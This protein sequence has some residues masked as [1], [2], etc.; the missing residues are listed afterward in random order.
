MAY[1]I[2]IDQGTTSTRAILFDHAGDVAG[3]GQVELTQHFPQPGWVEHDP[4][5]IWQS[6]RECVGLALAHANATAE[7][8]AAI[9]ITNQRE[10]AVVW[11]R[12]TGKPLHRAIVWQDARTQPFIDR[13]TAQH[14]ADAFAT[15]TGL[16]LA[17]Y[18][19]ASKY[20]WLLDHTGS[21]ERAERGEVLLGTI[22]SWL[23]WNL[24]G[25]AHG[26][27][28]ATDVTNASR[29]LLMDL[30]ERQWSPRMLAE[31]AIPAAAL[32]RI[33]TSTAAYGTAAAPSLLR[34]V[35]ITG[36]LGDQQAATFGQA[37]FAAGESKSTYGTG[38]FVLVNT[39]AEIVRSAHGLISTI[40]Y[41]LDTGEIAY[42]LE[43]S[44]AVTGAAVQWLRDS[45]GLITTASQV[46]SLAES[47]PDSGGVVFVPA[48]SGL[49]A[50]HWRADARGALLG[51][52]R[53]TGP[54][55]IARAT[56]EAVAWQTRQVLDAMAA[57]TGVSIPQLRVDG[58]MVVN[59]LLMQLQAD[60]LGV[61]VVRPAVTETTALGAAYAAGLAVG[62]WS[63][64]DELRRQWREGRRW[65]PTATAR[66]REAAYAQW[67]KGVDRSLG[68]VD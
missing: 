54:G 55:H 17:A 30:R 49:L 62:F 68:W 52:T 35:P 11:D 60:A 19:S 39:G 1:V 57:D 5:E 56:L 34:G 37:A 10:T 18:F 29:T 23:L 63:G 13:L 32:P 53:F 8:V 43:G 20:R 64:L 27:I 9:G 50:P 21:Q 42:A 33:R 3:M 66:H 44:V 38:N 65:E 28:H 59:D 26:G 47:V 24:T 22:D 40:A 67:C 61:A 41:E 14:G 4:E 36:V 48:F 12:A 16:P 7:D 31:F 51:M 15:L 46:E 25:G 58:G 2:A 45:L 6:V